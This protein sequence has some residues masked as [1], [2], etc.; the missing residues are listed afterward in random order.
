MTTRTKK[1]NIAEGLVDSA[2][3]AAEELGR[4]ATAFKMSWTHVQKARDKGR[5]AT[6]AIGRG[7][8]RATQ[9]TKRT[10]SHI[11]PSAKKRHAQKD[12]KGK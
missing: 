4:A 9:A 5:P 8:S 2:V 1:R 3:S 10:V 6:S 12:R 11:M 7:V